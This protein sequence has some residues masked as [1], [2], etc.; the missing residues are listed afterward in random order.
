MDW[1]PPWR[2]DTMRPQH[3][4]LYVLDTTIIL[5]VGTPHIPQ[6]ILTPASHLAVGAGEQSPAPQ[7]GRH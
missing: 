7:A 3:P 4:P 5:A 1:A 2:R 6:C